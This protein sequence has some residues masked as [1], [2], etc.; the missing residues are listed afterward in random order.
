MKKT[1][2]F[3]TLAASLAV[4]HAQENVPRE[5]LLKVALAVS[6]DLK[7]MLDTPIPTDPDIKRPVAVREGDRG[8]MVLPES[9][10]SMDSL[11]KAG[12]EIVPVGQLWLRKAVPQCDNHAAEPDK[13]RIVT[14]TAGDKSETAILCALGVRKSADGKLE[15]LVYGKE[16]EAL[17]R[18]PLK[19][20]SATTDNPIELSAQ[21]Q[22]ESAVLTLELLG[23]YTASFTVVPE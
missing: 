22:G 20:M 15:L 9:K 18:V 4:A 16:K 6:L 14:V 17:L 23:K 2:L 13:L 19:A 3:A 5:Q 8:C 21:A 11:A 10:L 1:L 12:K 7:Q